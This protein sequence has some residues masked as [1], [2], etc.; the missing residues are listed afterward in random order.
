[1]PNYYNSYGNPYNL[2][3]TYFTPYANQPMY[4]MNGLQQSPQYMIQVDGE[5]AARAWQM[6]NNLQPN[7]VVPLWDFDGQH[8][9]FKSTDNYG[10]MNPLRKARIVFDDDQQNL[11]Q[12]SSGE[13]SNVSGAQSIELP[14]MTKFVTK[15][16]LESFKNDLRS[17][18]TAQAMQQSGQ[19]APQNQNGN[20][21]RNN[22]G[23]NR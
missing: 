4:N 23:G 10:R 17:M 16:D 22:R 13:T 12:G 7:T 8:V 2:G 3:Q 11:P 14:D 15:E 20:E 19:N 18:F 1:M 21:N 6:P 5:M 9:Y